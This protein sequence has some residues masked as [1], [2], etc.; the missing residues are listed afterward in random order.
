VLL[1]RAA[2]AVVMPW[3]NGGGITREYLTSTAEDGLDWRLSVAQVA[4][5]GPFSEFP[6]L[7]RMLVL[8]EGNGMTLSFDDATV[9]L[10]D[11]LD[12]HRFAGEAA[13]NATLIDGPTRDL[14]LFWLRHRWTAELQVLR[15]PCTSP[16]G[17]TV[18]VY[19]TDGCARSEG[20]LLASG[21][22]CVPEE[23]MS[24]EGDA[25]LVVFVLSP[26]TGAC[27]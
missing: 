22:L 23:P 27:R 10:I 14:N 1:V 8:L 13:V 2:D 7:D 3:R 11:Q 6:G 20:Q 18:L 15:A 17:A 12:H 9:R 25:T 5:D 19:V 24:F 4:S 26:I 21:D 16:A